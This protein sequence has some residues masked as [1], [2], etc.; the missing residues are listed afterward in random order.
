MPS[1]AERIRKLVADNLEVDGEPLEAPE[2]LNVS[3]VDLGVS[4]LDIVAF[5]RVIQQDFNMQFEIEQCTELKSLAEVVEF[6]D[7]Q[8]A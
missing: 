3:L 2:D 7:A 8:G 5:A 1:T 4:S 6:L